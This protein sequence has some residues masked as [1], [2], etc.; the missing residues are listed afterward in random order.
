MHQSRSESLSR[1][2]I[3]AAS[4]TNVGPVE[5]WASLAAGTA[6]L[7]M[8]V[9]R[10]SLSLLF[11]GGVLFFRGA[12][13]FC[14]VYGALRSRG[15][16]VKI[17]KTIS[18]FR[19]PRE[20]FAMWRNLENLPRFMSHLESVKADDDKRSHWVARIAA[21]ARLEWDAVIDEEH[22]NE[23]ISWQSA[24]GS[25][26]EQAGSVY[27]RAVPGRNATEVR[28]VL[29]YKPPAGAVG[30]EVAKFLSTITDHQI[31]EDL[32]CFKAIVEAGER[33]T[34]AGQSAGVTIH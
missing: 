19:P 18:V 21:P 23:S 33:P 32:R 3:A 34:T 25:D 6:L 5:R 14:P 15:R 20:V 1:P 7:G 24:P 26:V 31:K 27:F 29:S 10:R 16:E 22:E 8:G 4:F 28:V 12:T 11:G 9:K 17:E 13:G 30:A 2:S